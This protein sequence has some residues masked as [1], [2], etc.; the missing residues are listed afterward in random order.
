VKTDLSSV[1]VVAERV[2]PESGMQAR[3]RI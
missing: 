2:Q 3:T 1:S